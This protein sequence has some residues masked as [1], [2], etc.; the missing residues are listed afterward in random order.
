[1]LRHLVLSAP[2]IEKDVAV[3]VLRENIGSTLR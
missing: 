1:M 2:V 3:D